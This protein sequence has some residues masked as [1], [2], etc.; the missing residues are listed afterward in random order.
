M[1]QSV[2]L[3]EAVGDTAALPALSSL[4]PLMAS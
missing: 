1:E 2:R 4:L 3:W